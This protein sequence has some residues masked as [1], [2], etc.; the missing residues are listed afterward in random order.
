MAVRMHGNKPFTVM[1]MDSQFHSLPD[2]LLSATTMPSHS[3]PPE[4]PGL[5]LILSVS[6][7]VEGMGRRILRLCTPDFKLASFSTYF[8]TCQQVFFEVRLSAQL[9]NARPCLWR[10]PLYSAVLMCQPQLSYLTT[11]Q[12]ET[13]QTRR[14]YFRLRPSSRAWTLEASSKDPS[15]LGADRR[16]HV[17][18]SKV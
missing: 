4:S 6:P 5:N 8:Q 14:Q 12:L 11:T 9:F 10:S 15:R 17:F 1:A 13:T 16:T 18:I 3:K 2:A 7:E